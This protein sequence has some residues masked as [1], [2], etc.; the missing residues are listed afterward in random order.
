MSPQTFN[1]ILLLILAAL[2]LLVLATLIQR[3]AGQES[4][5]YIFSGYVVTALI[6]GV[7]DALWRGGR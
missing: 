6:I 1:L 3:Q 5:A 4:A 7:G 2:Y